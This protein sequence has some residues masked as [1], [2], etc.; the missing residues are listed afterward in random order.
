MPCFS[1]VLSLVFLQGEYPCLNYLALLMYICCLNGVLVQRFATSKSQ[2]T[3]VFITETKS[4][5]SAF[6]DFMQFSKN[7]LFWRIE[8]WN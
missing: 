5:K 4:C 3:S 7:N 8:E 6:H 2:A 1:Y